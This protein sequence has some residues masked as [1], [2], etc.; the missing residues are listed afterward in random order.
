MLARVHRLAGCRTRLWKSWQQSGLSE[1]QSLSG[2]IKTSEVWKRVLS[3]RVLGLLAVLVLALFFCYETAG[4]E[5]PNQIRLTH[6]PEDSITPAVAM[7]PDGSSHIVWKDASDGRIYYMRVD[8]DGEV[9]VDKQAI[10]DILPSSFPKVAVDSNNT[11]HVVCQIN[12]TVG[13]IY[14]QIDSAGNKA[15][16]N[17]LYLLDPGATDDH[18]VTPDV[19]VDP[20]SDLYWPN[21]LIRSRFV[22]I[23]LVLKTSPAG[24]QFWK[25]CLC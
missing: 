4:A 17:L 16:H 25:V 2:Q 18:Y 7:G 6:D 3:D 1:I 19:F 5:E 9:M 15:F 13:I 8:R 20:S 10:Y 12:S 23:K 22:P 14:I 11:A 21:T 24:W